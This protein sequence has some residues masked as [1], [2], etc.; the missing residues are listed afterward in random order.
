MGV[1]APPPL[2]APSATPG[3]QKGLG[4]LTTKQQPDANEGVTSPTTPTTPL[5]PRRRARRHISLSLRLTF[6]AMGFG[7]GWTAVD[8][9][10][11]ELN[12]YIERYNDLG[13]ASDLVYVTSAASVAML[14]VVF[15][16]LYCA[17]GGADLRTRAFFEARPHTTPPPALFAHSAPSVYGYTVRVTP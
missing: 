17:P 11:Q 15:V 1:D 9:I 3:G 6:A 14:A 16:L 5:T 2:E 7:T 4:I 12:K 13:F 10:F 8:S